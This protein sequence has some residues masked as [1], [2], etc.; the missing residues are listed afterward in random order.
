MATISWCPII[1]KWDIYQPQLQEQ[2]FWDIQEFGAWKPLE[3]DF[4]Y[5]LPGWWVSSRHDSNNS[6]GGQS[7]ISLHH[8]LGMGIDGQEQD[9]IPGLVN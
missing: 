8:H 6:R 1:P 9:E 4:F 5:A 2:V 7:V 3:A